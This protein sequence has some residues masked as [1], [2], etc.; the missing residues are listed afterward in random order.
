ME[1]TGRMQ[2]EQELAA[3]V[4]RASAE[5]KKRES[6]PAA[7]HAWAL[8]LHE[9]AQQQQSRSRRLT[10]SGDPSQPSAYRSP[11]ELLRDASSKYTTAFSLADNPSTSYRLLYNHGVALSDLA[12]TVHS[13]NERASASQQ[14]A[15][16]YRRAAESADSFATS[17]TSSSSP[18]AAT[19]YATSLNNRGLSFQQAACDH[20]SSLSLI[21]QINH[22][23]LAAASFRDAVRSDTSFHRACYNLGTVWHSFASVIA[24]I[25]SDSAE[26]DQSSELA[27]NEAASIAAAFPSTTRASALDN[28]IQ[29]CRSL[30]AAYIALACAINTASKPAVYTRSLKLVHRY[31]ANEY[32][33][34]ANALAQLAVGESHLE[35]LTWAH[36][37]H[38]SVENE[39]RDVC[40]CVSPQQLEIYL[41]EHQDYLQEESNDLLVAQVDVADIECS[42]NVGDVSLPMNFGV[43]ISLT[44][45]HSLCLCTHSVVAMDALATVLLLTSSV[46]C[47]GNSH[48]LSGFIDGSALTD[49]H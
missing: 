41:I 33:Y 24:D 7:W 26:R 34:R 27:A 20:P 18:Q 9:L 12:R 30:S 37:S 49:E 13:P 40:V 8:S 44:S 1:E 15:E 2:R 42:E 46:R 21:E 19:V 16:L 29:N 5:A 28:A 43:W 11:E 6:S 25:P 48:A 35:L 38:G 47:N 17:A 4:V 10:P 36:R 23:K 31:L 39:W 22:L 32:L 3:A 14:A 45:G